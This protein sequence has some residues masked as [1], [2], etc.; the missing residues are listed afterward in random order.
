MFAKYDYI[1]RLVNSFYIYVCTIICPS[2]MA[3]LLKK[4]KKD[5]KLDDSISIS[6]L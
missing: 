2:T 6:A 3:G 5:K 1:Y 4:I